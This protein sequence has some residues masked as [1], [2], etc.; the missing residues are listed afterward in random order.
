MRV[1]MKFGGTGVD[2]CRNLLNVSELVTNYKR[3][4][5]YEIVVV[6]SAVRGVTDSLLNLTDSINKHENVSIQDFLAN[7]RRI[8]IKIIEDCIHSKKLHGLAKEKI[9]D[10]LGE[11]KEVLGGI[12]ILREVT[13]K[14]LDYLLSFG[15]RLSASLVSFALQEKGESTECLT[16]K[17]VGIVT[18]SNFGTAKPLMDTTRLRVRHRIER[19]LETKK[20]PVITGFIGSDQNDNITTL[21]RGGSD[22]TATIIAAS[23]NADETWL[24][25][26]VDGLMTADPKIASDA[27]VLKE[28]SFSEAMEMALFGA[29]YMHPRALEPVIEIGIP[30]RIRNT[31]NPSNLGT[32]ISQ[33]PSDRSKKIVKSVS[34][35]RQTGLIDVGGTAMANAPGTAAKIFDVLAKKDINIIMISQS[36][37]ES[38]ISMVLRKND[39]EKA[40]SILE[41]NLLGRVIRNVEVNS[42]VSVIAVVGSGMRGI[43]GVAARVFSAVAR[44]NVNVIM[45]AQGS[46]QLNLAFVVS[47]NDCET[48]V[49][50][51]HR[52]FDLGKPE[53][54]CDA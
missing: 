16:G 45:I 43:K 41:L 23:I 3:D 5:G 14:S 26:D 40:V 54:D 36:P 13:P 11:L 38:S 39:I 32:M 35:I 20:I 19:L 29:K 50:A 31:M 34:A 42:N 24:W 37:S 48:A 6:V 53:P 10:I 18:D 2:S 15:E 25:T 33:N 27:Q 9:T 51:L 7:L 4:N 17:E 30:V 12:V 8:H 44:E 28:I 22:Y 46:S 52:E 1:V 49:R 47:D 21:G